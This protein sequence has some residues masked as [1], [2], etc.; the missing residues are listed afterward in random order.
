MFHQNG[1]GHLL[2]RPCIDGKTY[3]WT[4]A[5]V[6][7]LIV[8]DIIHPFFLSSQWASDGFSTDSLKYPY[9]AYEGCQTPFIC[10]VDMGTNPYIG[11][12]PQH[13]TKAKVS[14][15]KAQQWVRSLID[16]PNLE[17]TCDGGNGMMMAP[18]A[19][20]LHMKVVKQSLYVICG[21][22]NHFILV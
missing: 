2:L 3:P 19:H 15:Q 5:I 8:V 11:L 14:L 1:T 13:C 16:V 18:Y 22:G 6:K 7:A 9:T 21:C 4:W 12:K 10:C 17:N 20:P